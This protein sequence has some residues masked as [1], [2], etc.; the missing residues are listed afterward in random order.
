M[1]Q[2]W[3]TRALACVLSLF[4]LASCASGDQQSQPKTTPV[5]AHPRSC[6]ENFSPETDYFPAKSTVNF[7]KNFTLEYHNNY[8]VLRTLNPAGDGAADNGSAYVL[9]QCGTPPPKLEG[10]LAK[11][12]VI[13]IPI[14]SLAALSTTFV[15]ALALIDEVPALTGFSGLE[16]LT[17]PA[18]QKLADD[19]KIANIGTNGQVS[20]EEVV[21]LQPDV[22]LSDGNGASPGEIEKIAGA[23]VKVVLDTDWLEQSPLGRAEWVKFISTFFNKEAQANGRFD[24]IASRYSSL[25]TQA[26]QTS[27]RPTVFTNTVFQGVWYMPGGNSYPAH[28]IKDAGGDYLWSDTPET[29]SLNLGLEAVMAK[30]QT[31]QTWLNAGITWKTTADALA[32]E[33]RYEAFQALQKGNVWNFGKKVNATGGDDFQATGAVR[34]DLVLADLVKILHPELV[35]AHELIWY[36]QVS[37]G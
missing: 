27:S 30:A 16:Y 35:P 5:A 14:R 12:Q 20:V 33:P 19:G 7:A 15:A 36:Q 26:Q 24:Q 22:L 25:A 18:A 9:V 1:F 4:L 32:E 13:D 10:P 11:A 37:V 28:L 6:V 8:K 31:A 21:S 23:G 2:H 3:L 29:G 17:T 34:P